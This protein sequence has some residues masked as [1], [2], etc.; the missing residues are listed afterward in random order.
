[1]T[2]DKKEKAT[3]KL[4]TIKGRKKEL[5]VKPAM[6]LERLELDLGGDEVAYIHLKV[7]N[8]NERNVNKLFDDIRALINNPGA[9]VV[10]QLQTMPIQAIEKEL[11]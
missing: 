9:Y 1:M 8:A 3:A 6:E 7:R 11:S 10:K 5:L 4:K 2:H